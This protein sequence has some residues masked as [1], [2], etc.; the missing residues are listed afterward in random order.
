[1]RLAGCGS[2]ACVDS[3]RCQ[4]L[5]NVAGSDEPNEICFTNTVNNACDDVQCADR[6]A[7]WT[8]NVCHAWQKS[9]NGYCDLV[10]STLTFFCVT[11]VRV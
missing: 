7:G 2:T 1:V 4:P 8:N 11:V 5:S 9:S 10:G 6:F 3:D